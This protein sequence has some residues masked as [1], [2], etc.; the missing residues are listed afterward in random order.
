ML[1][2]STYNST[3]IDI[4]P[5]TTSNILT[6]IVPGGG[7]LSNGSLPLYAKKRMDKAAELY[8][9]Y[10]KYGTGIHDDQGRNVR[11]I[12]LSAGTTHR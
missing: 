11:I 10:S 3:S 9:K 4:K 5:N 1:Y 12:T 2:T 8:H 6:I 7:L